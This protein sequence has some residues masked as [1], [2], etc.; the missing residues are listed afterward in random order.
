MLIPGINPAPLHST[1]YTQHSTTYTLL[2]QVQKVTLYTLHSTLYTLYPILYTLNHTPY[3]YI[4]C[5]AI[6]RYQT[7]AEPRHPL[8][9]QMR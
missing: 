3:T 4:E 5:D 8:L 7:P 2:F 9:T 1:L 6:A